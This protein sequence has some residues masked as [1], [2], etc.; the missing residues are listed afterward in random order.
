MENDVSGW[1]ALA[2]AIY[3]GVWLAVSTYYFFEHDTVY[4]LTWNWILFSIPALPMIL[5]LLCILPV[6]LVVNWSWKSLEIPV[7]RKEK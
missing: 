2:W 4:S 1:L 3:L 5:L 7:I 6:I